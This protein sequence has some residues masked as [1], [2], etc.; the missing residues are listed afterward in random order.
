MQS[1]E[2]LPFI[3]G[4]VALD[5]VNTAEERGHPEAGDVLQTLADLRLWGRRHGLLSPNIRNDRSEL[6]R[7]L[8]ARELLY[9]LFFARVKDLAP[10]TSDLTA[11]SSLAA[12]A[13]RA[14]E[15]TATAEGKVTWQWSPGEL[16]TVRHVAVTEA[17]N[18]LAR[19]PGR[20][21]SN[22]P[23][24]IAVG[25]FSTRPNAATDAGAR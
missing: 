10:E 17:V 6:R 9:A 24:N 18:L 3:A 12:A 2:E 22:V 15:L 7:A 23:A 5:F 4:N 1:I 19:D 25:S 16:S 21:S 20:A 14:A 11:L 8:A 13:Y